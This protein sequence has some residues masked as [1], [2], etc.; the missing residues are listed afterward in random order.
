M[1][2]QSWECKHCNSFCF[3]TAH[4]HTTREK[5]GASKTLQ[6]CACLP[7][8]RV[9]IITKTPT[10]LI[11]KHDHRYNNMDI[12]M[13]K[14]LQTY[15]YT[16]RHTNVGGK[17]VIIYN[18]SGE[19]FLVSWQNSQCR[20]QK[21]LAQLM[22]DLHFFFILLHSSIQLSGMIGMSNSNRNLNSLISKVNRKNNQN[23]T[24][25]NITEYIQKHSTGIFIISV[26]IKK[27]QHYFYCKFH[28]YSTLIS[29]Y[30]SRR[31]LEDVTFLS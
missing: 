16:K 4:T 13:Q 17:S 23:K 12:T 30:I 19:A 7:T 27:F 24:Y 2:E 31:H 5:A 6:S 1:K 28:S 21:A 22:D 11:V 8:L 26:L 9:Y 18:L 10:I 25:Y 20:L 14:L 29:H 3:T 15:M